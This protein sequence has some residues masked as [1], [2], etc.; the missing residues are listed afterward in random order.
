V[1]SACVERESR[2]GEKRSLTSE[3][4]KENTIKGGASKKKNTPPTKTKMTI[5]KKSFFG[6]GGNSSL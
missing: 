5:K 6:E 1:I 4:K 3:G 2:N